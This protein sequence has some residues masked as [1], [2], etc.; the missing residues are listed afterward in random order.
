MDSL[1]PALLASV[2]YFLFIMLAGNPDKM[3]PIWVIMGV[4][5][6]EL[7]WKSPQRHSFITFKDGQT[8][9]LVYFPRIIFPMTAV[10]VT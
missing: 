3:Y 4:V 6:L 5:V 2:Y 1:R 8:L 7:F 10:L 9:H